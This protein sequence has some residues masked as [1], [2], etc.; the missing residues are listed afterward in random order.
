MAVA[1]P[2]PMSPSQSLDVDL[3]IQ[4]LF[5]GTSDLPCESLMSGWLSRD[6]RRAGNGGVTSGSSFPGSV[7]SLN[8]RSSNLCFTLIFYVCVSMCVYT[9]VEVPRE[10]RGCWISWSC[11]SRLLWAAWCIPDTGL[12]SSVTVARTLYCWTA[13]P[14]L[15]C[16][17]LSY[18]LLVCTHRALRNKP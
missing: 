14:A 3:L 5:P 7:I 6:V 17:S 13:S 10:A 9:Q 8:F 12:E 2:L 15:P 4:T 16:V 18:L 11:S 1:T